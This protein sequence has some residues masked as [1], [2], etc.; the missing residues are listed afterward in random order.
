MPI[1]TP[2]GTLEV[3]NAKFRASSVEA[4]IAVGIG[5]ES[6]DAYPLQVFK[7]TSPDIRLSEGSTISSAA[8]FYS[9]NSN[10]YIQTG[11]N[12]T[13]GSSGDIA[14]QNM[15]GQSTHMMIK[16]DGKVGVGT[17][18]PA[19][20]LHVMGA[21]MAQNNGT[22]TPQIQFKSGNSNT[23]GWLVRANISDTYA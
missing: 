7:E 22:I 4:T 17:T 20:N 23:N 9:N 14:F 21:I 13:S 16:S 18:N 1:E 6:N 11:T 2:A 8:R 19:L 5:T 15:A 3:E 12:F 10:L